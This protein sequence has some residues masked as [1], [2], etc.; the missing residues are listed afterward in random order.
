MYSGREETVTLEFAAPALGAVY[1][2]FGE[3][4]PVEQ[5]GPNTGRLT[6]QVEISSTFFSWGA[7]FGSD[8]K[9]TAPQAVKEEFKAFLESILKDY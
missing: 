8:M 5:T 3:S 9:I 2:K 1:D 6:H 4:T 7:Q